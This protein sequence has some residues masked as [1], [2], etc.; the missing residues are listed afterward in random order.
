M[1]V[2][3]VRIK[4]YMAV[5]G[6]RSAHNVAGGNEASPTREG[7]FIVSS[8]G[9]HVSS[10]GG[11]YPLSSG[12]PW[13]TPLRF[14]KEILEVQLN[15][16]WKPITTINAAWS[17]M[18]NRG[19][20]EVVRSIA[21]GNG[22]GRIV[23]D[24]WVLNDFGHVTI[25]YFRDLNNNGMLDNKSE[26]VMSD[27]IHTTPIN[28]FETR[29]KKNVALFE[30]HG[31][32]HVKPKDIDEMITMEYLKKGN[33]FQVHPYNEYNIPNFMLIKKRVSLY[34]AHF[35]RDFIY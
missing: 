19:A 35:S 30:S 15:D 21:S 34:E 12:L 5:G 10:G 24:K 25:K 1:G 9:K 16:R 20:V 32:V 28:E 7:R 33:V 18:D 11:L 13:G 17:N 6:P 29:Q 2:E 23:P 4:A 8:I 22:L 27:F 3:L 26:R 31:C 14:N